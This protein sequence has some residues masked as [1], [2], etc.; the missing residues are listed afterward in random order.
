M[1]RSSWTLRV[2]SLVGAVVRRSPHSHTGAG[3]R[4]AELI[5][6]R[7]RAECAGDWGIFANFTGCDLL[8]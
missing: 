6:F 8:L 7:D 3:R 5:G 1:V 2:G 4:R